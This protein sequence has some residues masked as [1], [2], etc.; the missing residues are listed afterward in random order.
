MTQSEALNILKMGHNTFLTGQAGAG[1]TYV[2][3]QYIEWLKERSIPVAITASTGIAATH[4]GG[5]TLHSFAGLEIHDDLNDK[6]LDKIL[7]KQTVNRRVNNAS[8]LIIDEVSMLR[9]SVLNA[10]NI[11]CQRI[12]RSP[13][14]FGGL[15]VVLCGDFY[16][17][18]PVIINRE[19]AI[20]DYAFSATAWSESKFV[21]CYITENHRQ[22]DNSLNTIL[23][24]IRSGELDYDLLET[25]NETTDRDFTDVNHVKL[26]SHNADV[27]SINRDNYKA[28]IAKEEK[29]YHMVAMGN[30]LLIEKLKSSCLSP[31]ILKLKIGTKVMFTRNDKTGKYNNGTIGEVTGFAINDIPIILLNS[32]KQIEAVSDSWRI[33]EDNKVLAQITQLP[34]RYAWAITIHKS[35]GMTLDAAEIDLSRSFG[36]AL[37]YVALSRVRDI[38]GIKL[39]G[40][41]NNAFLIHPHIHTVDLDL[42]SRSIMAA[43]S[44][45]KYD[46]E[47]LDSMHTLFANKNKK[48]IKPQVN[49]FEETLKIIKSDSKNILTLEDIAKARSVTVATIITHIE[50]L[51]EDKDIKL[52]DIEYLIPKKIRTKKNIDLFQKEILI[53]EG[54]L[55]PVKLAFDKAKIDIS[56]EDLRLLRMLSL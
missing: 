5:T 52:E 45:K 15:Q 10:V 8:V 55:S 50:T 27:D 23:N 16:Q 40:A 21:I 51:L 11:V 17:L 36:Y 26:Y 49:T 14:P 39:L 22:E 2:L 35:Q 54:K 53:S 44:L 30:K 37:G 29:E 13:K 24:N 48:D 1:K 28:I 7:Q 33:E 31:E 41:N 46:K 12:R 34:L 18:P 20:S 32:G 6:L 9:S 3:N 42:R 43:T 56:Y 4:I 47:S 25:L 19:L 38:E